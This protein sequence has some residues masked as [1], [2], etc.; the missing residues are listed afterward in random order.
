MVC[1]DPR[2]CPY[3]DKGKAIRDA[4]PAAPAGYTVLP[5]QEEQNAQTNPMLAAYAGIGSVIEQIYE[6]SG[7]QIR[8][9]ITA[10]SPMLQ[11]FNMIVQNPAMV[12]PNQELIKYTEC[13][14]LLETQGQVVTLRFMLGDSLV[15]G[16]FN[17]EDSDFAL[18]MFNQAAVT[19]LN[20]VI[21]N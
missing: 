12:Q 16:T 13:S 11:M 4:L 7:K 15:E 20:N 14:A 6:G 2:L 5:V 17:G 1:Y 10:D 8:V 3:P 19:K 18:A 21:T 9:N